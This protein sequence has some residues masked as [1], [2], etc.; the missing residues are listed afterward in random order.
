MAAKLRSRQKA[1]A[2]AGRD[3]MAKTVATAHSKVV[4]ASFI[5][6]GKAA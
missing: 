3:Q 2:G 4:Q 5:K 1:A 6:A